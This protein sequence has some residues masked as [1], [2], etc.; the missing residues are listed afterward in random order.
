MIRS[1]ATNHLPK[2]VDMIGDRIG[3]NYN[4]R[5]KEATEEYVS[6]QNRLVLGNLKNSW[7]SLDETNT[8][9]RGR[10]EFKK[11]IPLIVRN[12]LKLNAKVRKKLYKLTPEEKQRL[13]YCDF[14]KI[15]KLWNEYAQN[16]IAQK[17]IANVF[18]M[19]LHGC[20]IIC[21]AS[22]NPTFTGKEGFV[23]QDTKNTFLLVTKTNR[24]VTIPK[25]ESIFE[26][27]IDDKLYRI[28]GC[29]FL[30]TVQARTK[31]KY[32]QQ[33]SKSNV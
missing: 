24:L 28:H 17:D 19:D 29:N 27:K 22:K 30:F 21:T 31:I 12:P 16:L 15:N 13:R 2:A 4:I 20:L 7:Y 3:L 18:K 23:V 8:K 5:R 1:A 6:Q 33:R 26:F 9:S 32:K 11:V 14:M 10:D 25:R